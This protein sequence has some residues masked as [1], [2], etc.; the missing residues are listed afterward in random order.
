M[1]YKEML[2]HLYTRKLRYISSIQTFRFKISQEQVYPV[3]N[4]VS[5]CILNILAIYTLMHDYLSEFYIWPLRH[6]GCS[7]L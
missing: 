7:K 6:L 1:N 3:G 5:T 2:N 4:L